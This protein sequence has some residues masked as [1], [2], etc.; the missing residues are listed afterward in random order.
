MTQNFPINAQKRFAGTVL[1]TLGIHVLIFSSFIFSSPDRTD[2]KQPALSFLGSVL[3]EQDFILN[4][5]RST[6]AQQKLPRD[7]SQN[8]KK[9]LDHQ[10][11]NKPNFSSDLHNEIKLDYKP[12]LNATNPKEAAREEKA[13]KDLGIDLK[14]PPR[15][16]LK[17]YKP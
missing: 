16:S 8:S 5:K 9:L 2:Q 10:T 17:L 15:P 6:A 12:D 13:E 1:F 11:I 4:P 7:F 3:T 14:T